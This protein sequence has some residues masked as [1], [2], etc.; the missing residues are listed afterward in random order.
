[1][2]RKDIREIIADYYC[3]C[4]ICDTASIATL[5]ILDSDITLYAWHGYGLFLN[6]FFFCLSGGLHWC[7]LVL[8]VER[9]IQLIDL[10]SY[11]LI[12]CV[13]F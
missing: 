12:I 11:L 3:A 7:L 4:A 8:I 5:R 13:Q 10:T 6:R 2:G 1:M 9:P